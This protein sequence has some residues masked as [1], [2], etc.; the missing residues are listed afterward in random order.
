MTGYPTSIGH[1]DESSISLLGHDLSA[2]LLGEVGF[3]ELAFWLVALRRPTAGE[4]RVF[5]AVLVAL[6]DHGFTPSVIAARLTLTGAPE[7]V[8]GALAAGLLG[9]G[10]RFLGATEDTGRFL[11]AALTARTLVARHSPPPT[12]AGTTWPARPCG[13]PGRPGSRCPASGTTCTGTGTRGRRSSSGSPPRRSCSARTCACSTPSD[14]CTR[15]C[16]AGRCRSTGRAPAGRPCA[17]S[18][19]PRTS[20]AGSR[21]WPGRPGWSGTSRRRCA[22]R[23]AGTSTPTSSGATE[24]QP[25][26]V[27]GASAG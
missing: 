5:E 17:T 25:P 10:S 16:S 27:P 7:S 20:C 3:A 8:Q 1:C 11:A 6:T 19:S 15:S 21:C 13:P 14:A 18:G 26:R 24:Y 12:T 2:D 4:L 9:G 23:S 22:A